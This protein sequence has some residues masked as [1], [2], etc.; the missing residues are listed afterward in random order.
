M[1]EPLVP[2]RTK[3]SASDMSLTLDQIHGIYTSR[4]ILDPN[5][6]ISEVHIVASTERKPKQIVRDIETMLF[7]KH[8][9]K[10]DYRK[11]SM[12]Q[13]PDEQ[14]LRIPI[15][16][17]EIARVTEELVGNKKRVQVE[18][19]GAGHRSVGEAFERID[20]PT[21]HHT[22]ANATIDAIRKLIGLHLDF[23]LE[24]AQVFGMGAHQILI[25]IIHC[26]IDNREETFIGS[27]FVGHRNAESAARA[28]LGALNRRIHNLTLQAPRESEDLESI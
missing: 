20:N 6:D 18:I 22:A 15:A 4:V 2:L 11:I 25:V 14:L 1:V 3:P 23:Q 19:R 13:I 16:R 10:V 8:S 5:R 24:D 9:T 17:P 28:T 7:V 12:V 21:P 27:S 26:L